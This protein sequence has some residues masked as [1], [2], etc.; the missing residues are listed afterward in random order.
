MKQSNKYSARAGWVLLSDGP[1]G[2][3]LIELLVVIAVIAILAALLLPSLARSKEEA[4]AA[5]CMSSLRQMGVATS[6]YADDNRDA[7]WCIVDNKGNATL[8]NGGSWTLNPRSTVLCNPTTDVQAYWALGYYSYFAGNKNL[9]GDQASPFV[10]DLWYDT[11]QW[12]A[13]LAFYQYSGYGMCR[14]LGPRLRQHRVP[15][16]IQ[17]RASN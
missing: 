16:P 7:Y 4:N 3:T 11:P 10:V 5:K 12:E 17:T 1:R 14:V 8:P 2:F 15:V 9:F 13:P 6:L